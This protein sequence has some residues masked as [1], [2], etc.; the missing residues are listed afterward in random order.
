[1]HKFRR[2]DRSFSDFKVA[3]VSQA[4]AICGVSIV[5]VFPAEAKKISP[6]HFC[7]D[8]AC[9]ERSARLEGP[10]PS[11]T[12]RNLQSLHTSVEQ[13]EQENCSGIST[14]CLGIK[15]IDREKSINHFFSGNIKKQPCEDEHP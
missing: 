12:I 8:A 1:M 14:G 10:E 5:D 6:E 7:K 11:G 3:Q 2:V 15:K 13:M 9:A 4:V